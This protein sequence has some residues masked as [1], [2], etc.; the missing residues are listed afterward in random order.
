MDDT[1]FFLGQPRIRATRVVAYGD[2][3]DLYIGSEDGRTLVRQVVLERTEHPSMLHADPSFSLTPVAAQVLMDDLWACGIR[4]TE[5]AGTAGAMRATER[6]LED[7]RALVFKLPP[8]PS[9]N[10]SRT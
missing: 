2:R 5:G 9:R 4:P 6:H 8:Q 1:E 7:M 10:G 3:I